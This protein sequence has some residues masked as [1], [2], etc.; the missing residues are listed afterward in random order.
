MAKSR[1]LVLD[2]SVWIAFLYRE[3]SQHKKACRLLEI[4]TGPII[5]PEYVL[6]EV[7][8]V[9]RQKRQASVVKK[10]V[11]NT[12]TNPSVFLPADDLASKT[13]RLFLTQDNDTLSFIDTALIVLSHKYAVITFDK[14][15]KRALKK[16]K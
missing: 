1:P 14:T 13:A 10:F 5:V 9:L 11:Q 15:L 6:L 16:S 7:A 4:E 3:D 8:T 12:I 2:S